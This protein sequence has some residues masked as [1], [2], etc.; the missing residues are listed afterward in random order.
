MSDSATRKM[1]GRWGIPDVEPHG[2][3]NVKESTCV[4]FLDQGGLGARQ[5][6]PRCTLELV[7]TSLLLHPISSFPASAGQIQEAAGR[8]DDLGGP[9]V[10]RD[11]ILTIPAGHVSGLKVDPSQRQNGGGF[12]DR[13]SSSRP[14]TA[15]NGCALDF[16][17]IRHQS[18]SMSK[19][20]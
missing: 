4:M 20:S 5:S 3:G 17:E 2:I 13:V 18:L 15:K 12:G 11:D 7:P 19:S 14:I 9:L 16:W 8:K 1:F 6:C 10:V